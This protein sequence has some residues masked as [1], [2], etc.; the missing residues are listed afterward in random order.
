MVE[1]MNEQLGDEVTTYLAKLPDETLMA[2]TVGAFL[3]KS[4]ANMA[5]QFASICQLLGAMIDATDVEATKIEAIDQLRNMADV[6]ERPI[7]RSRIE[8]FSS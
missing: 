4:N 1:V 3:I 5:D 8:K 7:I 2:I 6:I